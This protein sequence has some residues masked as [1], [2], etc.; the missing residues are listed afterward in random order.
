[1]PLIS[2]R[3]AWDR[4][5]EKITWSVRLAFRSSTK[6]STRSCRFTKFRG[7]EPAKRSARFTSR[8]VIEHVEDTYESRGD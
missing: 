2:F 4:V 7:R 1:M 8:T 5:G 3:G 6:V